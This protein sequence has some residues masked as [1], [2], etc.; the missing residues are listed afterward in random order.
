MAEKTLVRPSYVA[1]YVNALEVVEELIAMYGEVDAFERLFLA[2]GMPVDHR[3]NYPL[4]TRLAHAK[5]FVVDEFIRVQ[6]VAGGF[7]NFI[8]PHLTEIRPENI[9][10]YNGFIAGSRFNRIK[11]V[12][13]Y[14]EPLK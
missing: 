11:P 14:E 4:D 8:R 2:N 7:K 6:V 12:R 10:N 9:V 3:G 5:Y 1:E 13:A